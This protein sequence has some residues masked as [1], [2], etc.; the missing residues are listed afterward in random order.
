MEKHDNEMANTRVA[1]APDVTMAWPAKFARQ[2]DGSWL[3]TFR[4][5]PFAA[6]EAGSE[7]EAMVEA[8][9]C[10]DEA[11]AGTITRREPIP[12]AD[13]PKRGERMVPLDASLA[14]KALL[15]RVMADNG[16]AKVDLAARLGV[17]E[18]EVRR[19]LNPAHRGT[20]IARYEAALAACGFAAEVS[21]RPLPGTEAA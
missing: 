13:A 4:H 2:P 3:V 18:K 19:M 6:T 5:F 15:Y 11:V 7:A 1:P 9:D 10:L 8:R 20:R 14:F 17:D 12:A 16:V 21:A